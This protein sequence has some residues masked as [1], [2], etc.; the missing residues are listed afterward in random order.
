MTEIRDITNLPILH[1][2]PAFEVKFAGDPAAGAGTIEGYIS[3]YGPP[4]DLYG[5]IIQKGAFDQSLAEHRSQG[6]EPALL[7][8]HDMARPI[9][10]W[11]SFRSDDYGLL[12]RG[13]V[14]LAS[15]AGKQAHAHLLAGDVSSLSIGYLVPADGYQHQAGGTRLLTRIDLLEASIVPIGANRRSRITKIKSFHNVQTQRDF[16][17]WLHDEAGLSRAAAVK[18]AR[19]GWPALNGQPDDEEKFDALARRIEAALTEIRAFKPPNYH[20]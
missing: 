4:A 15:D 13:V 10:K 1:A 8:C 9:G 5:D 3:A 7:W 2:G 19:K 18:V 16:E 6:S 12:A 11:T 20:R 14:N 17:R